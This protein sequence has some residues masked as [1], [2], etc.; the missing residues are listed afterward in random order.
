MNS[1]WFSTVP[2]IAFVISQNVR[3]QFGEYKMPWQAASHCV[4][5]S[6]AVPRREQ[7]CLKTRLTGLTVSGANPGDLLTFLLACLRE[8]TTGL[9]SDVTGAPEHDSYGKALPDP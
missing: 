4:S 9:A 7:H 3:V 2:V 1:T 8:D 5:K 6:A